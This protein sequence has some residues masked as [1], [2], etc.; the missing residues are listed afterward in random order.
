MTERNQLKLYLVILSQVIRS[1]PLRIQE[2]G[3]RDTRPP[4]PISFSCSFWQK[5]CSI[6]DLDCH[7]HG[8]G[9]PHLENPESATGDVML[10]SNT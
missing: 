5:V 4:G 7:P 10:L 8:V 3:N 2:E 9:A 1:D 6:I